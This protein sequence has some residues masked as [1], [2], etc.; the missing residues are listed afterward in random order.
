MEYCRLGGS[1][2]E[3]SRLALGAIPFGTGLDAKTCGRLLDVFLDAGG[4]LVDTSNFYGGGMRGNNEEMAGTSE[5]TL[6]DL[7]KGKRDRVVLASKGYWLMGN[8]VR[9]NTVGLS[10]TYL[11]ENINNSLKRLQT[12][13]ID[14]YQ[15]HSWDFYTPVEESLYVLDEAI[16]DGKILYYGMSNWDGWHVVKAAQLAKSLGCPSPVSNQ[17][18]YNIADRTGDHSI[19]P[20]CR[21]QN[22][23]IIAWGALAEG[24]LTERYRQDRR[25][26]P[27]TKLAGD[28]F[29][30]GEMCEWDKLA[31][32][33]NWKTL[34]LLGD[35]A[36]SHDTTI[37]I[38]AIRWLLQSGACDVTLLGGSRLEHYVSN[39]EAAELEL[40]DDEV[41]RINESS[42]LP[43]P[44]PISFYDLFCRTD[45]EFYGGLR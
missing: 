1:G 7:I 19:I 31:I 33:R 32:D 2:L 6:G 30:P 42:K 38:V 16:R 44:Y 25:P 11:R 15:F 14:L 37:P 24:F 3:V 4:N 28:V 18:W 20:A 5:R 27:G 40:R 9:P 45:S 29:K 10:R 39:L 23:S 34:Y 22:V 43:A 13:H 26:Q 35:I 36:A 21:D 8:E 17:I 41:E 12:D